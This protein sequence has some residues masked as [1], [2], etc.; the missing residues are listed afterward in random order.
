[1]FGAVGEG[2]GDGAHSFDGAKYAIGETAC[3]SGLRLD[4]SV[5]MLTAIDW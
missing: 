5:T 3:F 2:V 4:M 1:M